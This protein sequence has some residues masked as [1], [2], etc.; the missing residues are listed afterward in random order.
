MAAF[1]E[2]EWRRCKEDPW[3]FLKTYPRTKDQLDKE[4]PFKNFPDVKYLAY[5]TDVY[6]TEK[7]V[8]VPKSRRTIATW[9]A[10]GFNLWDC[11]LWDGRTCGLQNEKDEKAQ[12][13]ISMAALM[14]DS[15]PGW[16]KARSPMHRSAKRLEFTARHSE[17]IAL[18]QGADVVRM[19]TF[20]RLTSDEVGTQ[21]YCPENY[22]AAVQTIIGRSME[23]SGQLIYIGT[24][25]DAWFELLVNDKLDSETPPPPLWRKQLI[26]E[27]QPEGSRETWPIHWGMEV[28]RQ[29]VSG[30]MTVFLHYTADP[31]KRS[32][33]WRLY[34][35]KAIS[36]EDWGQEMDIDFKAKSGKK[37]LAI[38]EKWRHRIVVPHFTPPSWWPRWS[39]HDYGLTKPYSCHFY[40]M[41]PDRTVYAYWEHYAPG[42]LNVHLMPIK[43]HEDFNVLRVM[44]LDATCWTAWQQS[45]GTSPEGMSTHMVKSI[46][47]M[48]E[49]AGIPV[50][51]ASKQVQDRVKIQAYLNHWDE[52]KLI[53]GLDP[54]FKIMDN[55][56][57]LIDEIPGI[58]WKKP[59]YLA[60][61]EGQIS[62]SLVDAN[63]HAFDD[64][65][66]SLLHIEGPG[67]EPVV[68]HMTLADVHTAMRRQMAEDA[69]AAATE[70]AE[71]YQSDS[72]EYF[73]DGLD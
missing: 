24:A 16:M 43:T 27:A 14:Y 54:T 63:N 51:P 3:Y 57:S 53:Q 47:Q 1:L 28:V 36:G 55:C 30:Y 37:A 38:F 17:M 9:H 35:R 60:Q 52:Q 7:V 21:K 31:E 34:A 29:S 33:A 32:E 65:S 26:P 58:R 40:T 72:Q 50:T 48:H 23:K 15:L 49:E 42:P 68:Q 64:A 11:L 13:M 61:Q 67:I 8:V 46:A 39:S 10:V 56:H 12:E 70:E 62:E 6:L 59:S 45:T 44:I 4:Q 25:K 41:A 18:P 66:Y 20:S 73:D 19:H 69:Y 71:S 22:K 5:L 2:L